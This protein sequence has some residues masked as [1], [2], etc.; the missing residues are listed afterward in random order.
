M[1]RLINLELAT[2]AARIQNI[3]N[4][5]ISKT[6]VIF[7]YKLKVTIFRICRTI[8]QIQFFQIEFVRLLSYEKNILNLS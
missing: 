8:R 3:N 2:E 1:R 6:T 4:L 7:S 5:H